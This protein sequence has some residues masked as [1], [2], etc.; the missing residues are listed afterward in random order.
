MSV[1]VCESAARV[2]RDLNGSR[3]IERATLL[4]SRGEIVA[5]E[6]LHH[7]EEEIV[8]FADVDDANDV[9]VAK[10]RRELPL[11]QKARDDVGI[12][13][14]LRVD[15]LDG[16]VTRLLVLEAAEHLRHAPLPN[17]RR[18]LIALEEEPSDERMR[19]LGRRRERRGRYRLSASVELA[20]RQLDHHRLLEPA[21]RVT[22]AGLAE[23]GAT[24][25]GL[26][27]RHR[28]VDGT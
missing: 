21:E 7:H 6:E 2:D 23:I 24:V 15:D 8:V 22:S 10:A 3:L 14:E 5:E 27:G 28:A 17:E 13:C 16:D 20:C 4:D 11:L 18:D 12:V 25:V 26:L 9:R 19:N 1:R